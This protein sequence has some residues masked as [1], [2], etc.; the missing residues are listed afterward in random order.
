MTVTVIAIAAWVKF[1]CCCT[2]F[3][4]KSLQFFSDLT[5]LDKLRHALAFPNVSSGL[6]GAR[7]PLARELRLSWLFR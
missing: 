1:G 4:D 7:H 5:K 2:P 6:M 3:L